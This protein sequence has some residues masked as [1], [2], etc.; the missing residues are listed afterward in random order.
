LHAHTACVSWF[1]GNVPFDLRVYDAGLILAIFP[2]YVYIN[3]SGYMD[4][5]IGAARFLKLELPENFNA[6]LFAQGF[7]DFWGRWHMT[8]STWFKTYVYSPM[9]SSAMRRFPAPAMQPALGILAYFFTF[10]LVGIWHGQ[11]TMFLFYGILQGAGV[12]VNKLYQ[13][14][15]VQRLGHARYRAL[16]AQLPY[17][18]LS[19]GLTF[20]YFAFSLLWFWSPSWEQLGT[21]FSL[22]GIAGAACAITLVIIGATIVLSAI[23]YLGEC[24]RNMKSLDPLLTSHYARAA[25]CTMLATLI[26]SVTAMLNA[27]APHIIYKGY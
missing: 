6:P 2:V 15:M 11:T 20:T 7:I 17:A 13:I 16:C 21:F 24:L 12:S 10:F 5:V 1:S 14:A 18:S 23:A 4:C 22:L 3:F 8:L 27:P 9:L 19:R 25:W 26:L